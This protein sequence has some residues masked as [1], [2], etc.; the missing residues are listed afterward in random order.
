MKKYPKKYKCGAGRKTKNIHVTKQTITLGEC[1]TGGAKYKLFDG[2]Y[3]YF[4][5]IAKENPSLYGGILTVE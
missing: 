5:R 4:K 1:Y 3:E 2:E